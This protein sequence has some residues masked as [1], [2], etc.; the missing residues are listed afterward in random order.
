MDGRAATG[1]DCVSTSGSAG[2]YGPMAVL[3]RFLLA[4]SADALTVN[5]LCQ[6]LVG[7]PETISPSAM[8]TTSLSSCT[9]VSAS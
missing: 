3:A 6:F 9:F 5:D 1:N 7:F 2:A 4:F 8:C